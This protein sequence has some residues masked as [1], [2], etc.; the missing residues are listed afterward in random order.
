MHFKLHKLNPFAIYL[1]ITG[2]GS[3]ATN[4]IFSINMVYQ[5]ET[6]KLNPLQLVLVGTTLEVAC[7]VSQVPTG[8]LADMYSRRM[9][10]VLG[11][12]LM[13]VGFLLEGLIPSFGAVLGAQLLWGCGSTFVSGA[14]EAWCADEIGEAAV[15]NAFIRGSQ[16]G[17]IASLLAIPL[18]I[19]L[20]IYRINFPIILGAILLLLLGCFLGI[21]MPEKNF[22][23][24]PREERSSWHA[25]GKM[26]V[27]GGK[28]VTRNRMLLVILCITAFSAMSSEGF[29]RL[30]TDHFIK[31]FTF[32]QLWHLSH[33]VWFGIINMGTSILCL[34]V[35]ELVR[36]RVKPDQHTQMVR[37]MFACQLL[38][39]GGIIAFALS[40][41]FYLALITFWCASI[42][43][44][45]AAPFYMNWITQNSEPRMRATV[46]SMFGQVDAIGQI[47]GGPA[48]GYIGTIVSL[49]AAL[50]TTS[51]ILAPN[52]FF[53]IRA[54]GLSKQVQ[55][56]PDEVEVETVKV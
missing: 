35:T 27:D 33:L 19:G 42:G 20:A 28:A 5:I 12:T 47:A 23:P 31:D 39:I 10:V 38:L 56:Y 34:T 8:V 45:T 52:I 13:G 44:S 2:I 54:L 40:G 51:A 7:F 21:W 30:Q 32:P 16:I 3:F 24:A 41:N 29:D 48:V 6:V 36:R 1:L 37:V 11:Y 50:L 14:E 9:A 25:M 17:Q 26:M 46:I 15:G 4:L 49:R 22:H 55:V 18:G 43:R 53:F